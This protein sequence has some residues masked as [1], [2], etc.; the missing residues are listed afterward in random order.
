MHA[1]RKIIPF[2]IA[3]AALGVPLLF[4]WR[5]MDPFHVPKEVLVRLAGVLILSV[6]AFC[7]LGRDRHSLKV[8]PVHLPV[9]VFLLWNLFS[10]CRTSSVIS[11]LG[12]LSVLGA[13]VACCLA[14]VQFVENG[15]QRS[16]I[17]GAAVAAGVIASALGILQ[18]FGADIRGDFSLELAGAPPGKLRM[19][20]TFG[21]AN[22]LAAYLAA[23]IPVSLAAAGSARR[24]AAKAS[25]GICAAVLLVALFLTRTKGGWLGAA[26]GIV[27][28]L[29]GW[30]VIIRREPGGAKGRMARAAAAVALL[31]VAGLAVVGLS[32]R[33][34]VALR[35]A[36]QSFSIS[37]SSQVSRFL[38]WKTGLLMAREHPVVGV[39]PGRF[40]AHYQPYQ[41]RVLELDPGGERYY[42]VLGIAQRAH[43]DYIQVGAEIGL[44]G[45]AAL[46]WLLWRSLRT[47]QRIIAGPR[48]SGEALRVAGLL[49]GIGGM[50][51]HAFVSSPLH[52]AGTHFL[53]WLFIGLLASQAELRGGGAGT[54]HAAG[55]FH[56]R[57]AGAKRILGRAGVC[58]A[59]VFL[60][61]CAIRPAVGSALQ[62]DAWL[63]MEA[64]HWRAALPLAGRGVRWDP[65]NHDMHIYRGT[66]YYHIAEYVR[67]LDPAS[68][69]QEPYPDHMALYRDGLGSFRRAHGL[70]RDYMALYNTGLCYQ[71]LGQ[72]SRAEQ[73]FLEAVRYFPV[74]TEAYDRLAESCQAQGRIVDSVRYR[75]KANRLRGASG[76]QRD[77]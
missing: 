46:L 42:P 58:V 57:A 50:L 61:A 37:D 40:D 41:G 6:W 36:R 20:S 44:V 24:A 38:M 8:S 19:Y 69:E 54:R 18:Y 74:F 12:Y 16:L 62:R 77:N 3:T 67:E 35:E 66:A 2:L 23:V 55:E 7:F 17:L 52:L 63:M 72:H 76:H 14:T 53:F 65:A 21:N 43:N 22:F 11:S 64:G 31:C 5:F 29:I 10:L 15:R 1:D 9:A 32:E 27:F 48:G 71:R 30:A 4:C 45:L 25:Y 60:A 26:A 59:A 51:V 28:L 34:R 68:R 70:Y 39:G 73:C 13:G 47:G 49:A 56:F 33:G 75:G